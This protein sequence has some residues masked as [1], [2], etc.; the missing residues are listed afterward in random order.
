MVATERITMT[1]R[2]LDRF[3]VI[4]DVYHRHRLFKIFI[5]INAIAPPNI[6]DSISEKS[7]TAPDMPASPNR[8]RTESAH[9]VSPV[10]HIAAEKSAPPVSPPPASCVAA[11]P[12]SHC[13][14]REESDSRRGTPATPRFRAG[15]RA[16]PSSPR[17][18]RRPGH[19]TVLPRSTV[20]PVTR[21]SRRHNPD[22]KPRLKR[23][24]HSQ[25]A[26][27]RRGTVRA[28]PGAHARIKRLIQYWFIR[29]SSERRS[30]R[31]PGHA[32]F[33]RLN[34]SDLIKNPAQLAL[35]VSI[36]LLAYR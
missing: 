1:M 34:L 2:E 4:Q 31:A 13:A 14:R 32:Y 19:L 24:R 26:R 30:V 27:A 22:E 8:R 5:Q 33:R 28:A 7:V 29:C 3:K 15:G 17:P 18:V 21:S 36:D 9:S 20:C 6:I 16:P 12:R 25:I 23:D 11:C 35:P 10:D